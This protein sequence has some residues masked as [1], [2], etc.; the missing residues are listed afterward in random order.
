[1]YDFVTFGTATR[2]VFMRSPA[3]DTHDC[4]NSPSGSDIGLHLGSKIEVSELSLDTGGGAT[5][6]AMTFRRLGY[7]TA[8]VVSIG[9]DPSGRDITEELEANGIGTDFVQR[10]PTELTAYAVILLTEGGERTV[11]VYRGAAGLLSADSVPWGKIKARWFYVTSISDR[12]D[13]LERVIRQARECGAKIAWNPG[14]RELKHGWET[15]KPLIS[16]TDVFNLNLEEARKLTGKDGL[17]AGEALSELR[18]MPRRAAVVT[19]GIRGAYAADSAG[20]WHSGVLDYPKVN[21]TGAGDAFG[22]GLVAGLVKKDDLPF[23]MAV[24][25]WNAAGVVQITGAKKGI[26]SS[27]PPDAQ[28]AQ[29]PIEKL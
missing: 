16:Q 11:L 23:G 28:V 26:L 15:L 2:D 5:N 17:T 22:S 24:G 25:T 20:S 7:R 9:R 10:H 14:S 8:T 12:L 27:F 19:D 18:G 6:A 13:M 29:V 4:P 21:A 3:F 1:M